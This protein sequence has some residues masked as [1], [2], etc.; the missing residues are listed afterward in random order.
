MD[1]R[2]LSVD[3]ALRASLIPTGQDKEA[4]TRE[5]TVDKALR[6]LHKHWRFI[7][8]FALIV[9][10]AV[11]IVTFKMTNIYEPV[12][13]LEIDPPGSELLT[14]K[15]LLNTTA[16]DETY[17]QTQTKILESDELAI[18]VIRTL[19]L[20]Q[21]P[22]FAGKPKK[23][24]QHLGS[25]PSSIHLTPAEDAAL[26]TFQED[27]KILNV[28]G[29]RL[30][31]ARYP[32]RDPALAA[33]IVNTLVNLYIDRNYRK[34]YESTMQAS[35]WLSGQLSDLRDKVERSSRALVNYQKENGIVD[36]PDEKQNV[37]TERI[38]ELSHQFAQ[39]QADRIE[40]EAAVKILD[41][42][43]GDLLPQVRTSPGYQL[44][45]QR[46]VDTRSLLAQVQAVY[47]ENSANVKKL[48]N[49]VREIQSELTTEKHDIAAQLRT[50]LQASRE[51]EQL[52]ANSLQQMK[53]VVANNNEK[54][55][56]YNVLKNEA[57]ANS[58]LYNS[59]LAKLKEAGISAGLKS[60]NIRVVD[61]ARILDVPTRP[62]RKLDIALGLALGI[63]GG[64]ILAFLR[65]KMDNTIHTPD[66]VKEFVGLPS[67]AMFPLVASSPNGNRLLASRLGIGGDGNRLKL[68]PGE[69]LALA[70]MTVERPH[71]PGAEA[72][73][74]LY[75]SIMLSKAGNPP[76]TILVVSASPEEGK[77]VVSTNLATVLSQYSPTCLVECDLRRPRIATIFDLK[78][79]KGLT[80]VLT[81]GCEVSEVLAEIPSVPNLRVLAAGPVP[82]NP[83]ELLGSEV[84]AQVISQLRAKFRHVI[85]DSPPIIPFADARTLSPMADGVVI[86][87]RAGQTPVR[88]LVR[89][90][91]ILDGIGA[92]PLGV[93]LNGVD[94]KSPDYRYYQYGRYY[95]YG[96]SYGY[97]DQGRY[98]RLHED[99]HRDRE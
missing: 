73:R 92:Y 88:S 84:M 20:D 40:Y 87:C 10:V 2:E 65:E 32:S 23:P 81:G 49:E 83:N 91:E 15:E 97:Y 47:G 39:A 35:D 31:E 18:A 52:L 1:T 79:P 11:T 27:L 51:R 3:K 67:L 71:S 76:Q 93:V 37:I 30:V 44:L 24:T 62:N 77:T 34:R 45:L 86:V 75:T 66:D 90:A 60:S 14:L 74:T 29:S 7:G 55:I 5:L 72:V 57:Q 68:P 96:Y 59:L 69:K 21:N 22:E 95:N 33:Q 46:M 4:T 42:G 85:F 13:R 54:M 70:R 82:P 53:E 12:A 78:S 25:P 43:S 56:Q 99:S 80:N 38:V 8:V 28:R 36:A 41:K 26:G 63:L 89:L 61:A 19:R 6:T 17:L 64:V 94:F 98:Y 48:E 50:G 58:E 16:S 9:G